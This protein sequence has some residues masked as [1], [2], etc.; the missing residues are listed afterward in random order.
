[1]TQIN[2]AYK[3]NRAKPPNN[4]K[5]YTALLSYSLSLSLSLSLSHLQWLRV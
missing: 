2:D 1:V 3:R 5:M 4:S